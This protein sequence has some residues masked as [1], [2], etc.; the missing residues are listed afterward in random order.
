VRPG[1]RVQ[2]PRAFDYAPAVVTRVSGPQVVVEVPFHDAYGAE[3]GTE[4]LIYPA[5]ALRQRLGK[6]SG[7][8]ASEAV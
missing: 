3:L 6:G 4:T 1:D 7:E 2:V 5:A 8:E